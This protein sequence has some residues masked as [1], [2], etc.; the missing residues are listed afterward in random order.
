MASDSLKKAKMRWRMLS[1]FVRATKE[2]NIAPEP[3][4]QIVEINAATENL[5]Y[6]AF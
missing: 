1:N 5:T 3:T 4:V 2:P 6:L